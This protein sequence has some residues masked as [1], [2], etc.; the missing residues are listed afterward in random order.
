MQ[1]AVLTYVERSSPRIIHE[2]LSLTVDYPHAYPT[3]LGLFNSQVT[4]D[5]ASGEPRE[6]LADQGLINQLVK[7]SSGVIN[8]STTILT[9][10]CSIKLNQ[11]LKAS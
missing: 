9:L 8:T 10:P 4:A 2:T 6:E 3:L 11:G 5:V 1:L 7:R